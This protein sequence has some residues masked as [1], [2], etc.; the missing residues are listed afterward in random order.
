MIPMRPL[1]ILLAAGLLAVTAPALALAQ[2]SDFYKGKTINLIVGFTPG[3]GYDLYARLLARHM[4]RHI[5]GT[6]T[7]IVEN[8]PSAGSLTAVRHLDGTAPKDG[9]VMT[10]FNPGLL[11]Q[12]LTTPDKVSLRLADYSWIGSITRDFRVCYAWSTTGIKS[13]DDM[14]KRKEFILGSTAKGSGNYINGAELRKIFSAPVR[15]ILG[16]PGSAEQRLSIENG[17]LDG[18]CGSWTSIPENFINDKKVNTFVRFSE[19]RYS[20]IPADVPWIGDFTKTQEQ[21]DLLGMLGASDEVGRP[22]IMSK[23][24]PAERVAIIRTAFDDTMKDQAFID[25]ATKQRLS[26]S[27]ANAAECDAIVAKIAKASPEL[28]AKAKDIYE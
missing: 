10:T 28:V 4:P 3:G 18:D 21:K 11:I 9:T 27:P 1:P 5:P 26:I 24:V 16:F 13:W 25:E 15:Q 14:M 20:E 12:T 22:Y 23:Q 19:V 6:P 17:E 7:I 8:M 2:E